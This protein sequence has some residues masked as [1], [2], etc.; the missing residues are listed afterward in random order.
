[1]APNTVLFPLV[2]YWWIYLGFVIFVL[3]MLV[4]DLGVLHRK[5]HTVSMREALLWT[6]GCIVLALLFNLG[7][8]AYCLWSFPTHPALADLNA[9][10][11]HRMAGKIALE[12]LTGYVVEKSLA[13]DNIFVFVIV[14]SFFGIPAQYQHRVLHLGIIGALIFRAIFIALGTLLLQYSFVVLIFGAFLIFTGVKMIFS[15]NE[16]IDPSKN[17]ILRLLK[18]FLP[19]T[20]E[21]HG[22]SFFVNKA[23]KWVATPLFI[24]LIF[25]EFTDI[26]FAVDSVPAIFAITKEPLIIFTSNIFAILS[27]RSLYFLLAGSVDKF[28]LLQYGLAAVLIFVGLKMLWLNDLYHGEFPVT[29]SLGIIAI[30]IGGSIGLSLLIPPKE[31]HEENQKHFEG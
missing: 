28:H 18:R 5:A 21:I 17:F 23:G 14:F 31:K 1:M 12:F 8:Y 4:M 30:C 22:S 13:I 7:L 2:D 24:A 27:L 29:W 6:A 10:E 25:L 9:H 16:Q 15:D 19:V 20:P 26:L 11:Q 3:A